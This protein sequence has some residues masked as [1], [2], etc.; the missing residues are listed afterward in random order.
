VSIQLKTSTVSIIDTK[1]VVLDI[2]GLSVVFENE[3]GDVPALQSINLQVGRGEIVGLV[4][5]SGCGKSLTSLSAMRLL[6][7]AAKIAEGD[8]RIEGQTIVGISEKKMR[9]IRGNFISMIFQEPMTALNPLIKVGHQIEESLLLHKKCNAKERY[10]KAIE[11]LQDVGIP[12]PKTRYHQFP[13]ELSGGMRQRV[14]IALALACNP[15]V[16]IA[17]EPTT[18]LDVTIQAQILDLLKEIRDQYQTAI[19]LITHDMGVIAD[20]ADRVAVMYAGQ[21]VEIAPVH[22][23]FERPSHPYTVGL[24]QSIPQING[25]STMELPSIPGTVPDLKSLPQGCAFQTRC[26]YVTD[27]CRKENPTLS[28]LGNEHALACWNPLLEEV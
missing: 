13:F 10:K 17:D 9:S 15:K 3:D 26:A 11:L 14:M 5:E 12:E 7:S 8:I 4:G 20:V 22:E 2:E 23:L 24:L 25:D 1:E 21:I 16:I 6:P 27:K 19:L 28:V 18:A